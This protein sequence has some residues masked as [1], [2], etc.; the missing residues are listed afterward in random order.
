MMDFG[1]TLAMAKP[2]FTFPLA[3]RLKKSAVITP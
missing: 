3:E 2:T 1:L